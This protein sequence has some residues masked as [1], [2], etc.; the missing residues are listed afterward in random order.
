MYLLKLTNMN[1][2]LK[3]MPLYIN[4][5]HIMSVFELPTDGGSLVTAIY[6]TRGATWFVEEGLKEVV[7]KCNGDFSGEFYEQ[8]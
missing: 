4:T 1:E 5:E 8:R 2:Q 7:D 6:G 3:G